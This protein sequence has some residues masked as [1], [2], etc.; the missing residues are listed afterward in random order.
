MLSHV[1]GNGQ[2]HRF[3]L[4]DRCVPVGRI[5]DEENKK[6]VFLFDH[7]TMCIR[8]MPMIH[9][10]N[11]ELIDSDKY[12][13]KRPC[14]VLSDWVYENRLKKNDVKM[15][16]KLG[17]DAFIV[18]PMDDGRWKLVFW[19]NKW[20]AP[21]S[22]CI[23][24][25]TAD[26]ESVHIARQLEQ[27]CERK[28]QQDPSPYEHVKLVDSEM[29][30]LVYEA[31]CWASV[32]TGISHD[33]SPQQVFAHESTKVYDELAFC[34]PEFG[35]IRELVKVLTA[36][37]ILDGFRRGNL[38]KI[39]DAKTL[40]ARNNLTA[41]I[42]DEMSSSC[43]TN[44]DSDEDLSADEDSQGGSTADKLLKRIVRSRLNVF[45]QVCSGWMQA[46]QQMKSDIDDFLSQIRRRT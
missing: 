18:V 16:E 4:E 39:K 24:D 19:I 14:F 15:Q 46:H 3:W 12:S 36:I 38:Q 27:L 7:A 13:T 28:K 35:R 5:V 17:N 42:L 25:R 8:T 6:I 44:I 43:S 37:N 33:F 34:A 30:S 11:G 10:E 26:G 45:H 20:E 21:G 1:R 31:I 9:D 23:V 32:K 40:L 29:E 2:I 41:F 22:S